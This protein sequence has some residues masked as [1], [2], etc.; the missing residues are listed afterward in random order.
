MQKSMI[1]LVSIADIISLTNAIF[2]FLAIL[3]L[4][5][6]LIATEEMRLRISFSFILL[7]LLADGLDGVVARKTRKSDIGEY[8]ESM[9]DMTS[10]NIAPAVFIYVVYHDLVSCCIYSHIYL[11][12]ALVVF[13]LFGIIRLASFHLMRNDKLFIG[14]PA[15]ASTIILLV[16]V[17]FE[18]EFI[19]ILPA[20]IVISLAM[21]TNLSFPKPG[22]KINVVAAIL[23][24]LTIIIGK[25]YYGFA[26]ILLFASI[27]I[28]SIAGPFFTKFFRK[29][30]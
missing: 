6:D 16:L 3:F 8:L 1:K 26:P 30:Q 18:V 5:S 25:S 21:I 7:A 12:M 9:A 15:S 13:L 24:F 20:I 2:G 27:L 22:Y 4:I 19:Y 11:L 29:N 10:L 14:L 23:I 17:Y 28:Y